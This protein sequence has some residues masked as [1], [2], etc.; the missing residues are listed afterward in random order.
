MWRWGGQS[1]WAQMPQV[2]WFLPGFID[3]LVV[4]GLLGAPAYR[5]EQQQ[6]LA[7]G[8]RGHEDPVFHLVAAGV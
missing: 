3:Q 5:A 1:L 4:Q 8:A 7:Q 2:G 6:V